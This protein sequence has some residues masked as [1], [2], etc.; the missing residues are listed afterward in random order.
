MYALI[1]ESV[2]TV[3]E[4]SRTLRPVSLDLGL[5]SALQSI[6]REL[7][8]RSDVD[9]QTQIGQSIPALGAQSELALYRIAQEALTN[10]SNHADASTILMSLDFVDDQLVLEVVDDGAGFDLNVRPA[11]QGLGLIGMRERASLL[12][13]SIHI[14]SAPG[15]GTRVQVS[16]DANVFKT[17][18]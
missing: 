18:T 4:V 12:G 3:R 9:I 2:S 6:A 15:Q 7:S 10:A 8:L 14:D 5:P 17:K 11:H 1:K 16:L 13:A